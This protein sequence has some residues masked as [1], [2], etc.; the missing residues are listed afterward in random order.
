MADVVDPATRS[1]M[2][3]GIRGKD[4]RPEMMIRRALHRLG[5]RYRLHERQLP[6]TPDLVFPRYRAV[7]FVHGCFWHFHGCHLFKWPS[8]RPEFWREK[9][10][11]NKRRDARSC[12]KLQ[13]DGWRIL[14]IWECALK[15]TARGSESE[16]FE[17]V[18]HWLTSGTGQLELPCPSTGRSRPRPLKPKPA[19][20]RGHARQG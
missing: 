2:M 8:S 18:A 12:R 1:R 5:F 4:T 19:V 17:A 11:E 3:A 13:D 10:T 9:I 7:I 16:L 20:A 14:T 6:G 15:G